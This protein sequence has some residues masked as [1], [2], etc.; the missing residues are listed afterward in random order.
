MSKQEKGIFI[1]KIIIGITM[2]VIAFGFITMLLWNWLVPELFK[3]P[4]ITFWQAIGLLILSKILFGGP[5]GRGWAKKKSWKAS[6]QER[7]QNMSPEERE[8]FRARL[9][10]RCGSYMWRNRWTDESRQKNNDTNT[11]AI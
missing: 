10:N 7:L 9:K 1:M 5:G 8:A 3:G 11:T 6:M 4:V 2:F